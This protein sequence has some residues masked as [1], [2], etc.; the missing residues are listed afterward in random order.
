MR[1]LLRTLI[2]QACLLS[3]ALALAKSK[4]PCSEPR[5]QKEVCDAQV[6][7]ITPVTSLP[8]VSVNARSFVVHYINPLH[9]TYSLRTSTVNISAPTPPTLLAAPPSTAAGALP[10]LQSPTKAPPVAGAPPR[11]DVQ[12]VDDAW[13]DI[14]DSAFVVSTAITKQRM[15]LNSLIID[16]GSEQQCYLD[17]LRA[18]S[19]VL[20]SKEQ[21]RT[22]AEFAQNNS[23]V[24][25]SPGKTGGPWTKDCR[26]EDSYQ[27]PSQQFDNLDTSLLNLQA[28][29]V[30]LAKLPGYA[31][32]IAVA[33]NKDLNDKLSTFFSDNLKLVEGWQGAS[34][35]YTTFVASISYIT[36][37]RGILASIHQQNVDHN[38]PDKQGSPFYFTAV[39]DCSSNWYGRGRTDTISLHITDFSVTP[40][41]TPVDLQ[42]MTNTCYPPGTISTGL[43]VSFVHDRVY[44]FLPGKDPANPTNTILVVGT[45]TDSLATPLYAV[46]YNIGVWEGNSSY[47]LHGALGAAIGSTSGTTNLEFLLGPAVSIRRRAFFITPAFQLARRDQLLPG[48]HV[49]SPQGN[50]LTSLP[51]KTNWQAGFAL[52]FTFSVAP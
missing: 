20:L 50:G 37:W 49:G 48:Y 42:V 44:T 26:S 11:T 22:L 14:R 35:A 33:G 4:P 23:A 9:Y 25:W 18:Y 41:P 15:Q 29:Q 30:A 5:Q 10:P 40:T 45:T 1:I 3:A 21:V 51:V 46:Q 39:V 34:T 19:A 38:D 32:W 43:G 6:K 16:A 24:P 31:A 2:F 27:W 47:G 12:K 17:R 7:L 8:I 36:F 28:Q 52:T 13:W